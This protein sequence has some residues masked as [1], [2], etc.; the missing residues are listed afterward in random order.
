MCTIS[1]DSLSEYIP[2]IEVG[3]CD[4]NKEGRRITEWEWKECPA[5]IRSI[6]GLYRV[7]LDRFLTH[8][9][10]RCPLLVPDHGEIKRRIHLHPN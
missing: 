1:L 6:C 9:L 3:V 4:A 10:P 7:V 5:R 2:G 8:S